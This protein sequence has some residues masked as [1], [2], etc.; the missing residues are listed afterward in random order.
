VKVLMLM[1][2]WLRLWSGL[3]TRFW[4]DR[5]L[6]QQHN[7]IEQNQLSF[8]Q[9]LPFPSFL[10]TNIIAIN[11]C[12]LVFKIEEHALRGS[13][14][15]G[16]TGSRCQGTSPIG[17]HLTQKWAFSVT[18]YR[19]EI[20]KYLPLPSAPLRGIAI[21]SHIFLYRAMRGI[22]YFSVPLRDNEHASLG[23]SPGKEPGRHI[24]PMLSSRFLG[25]LYLADPCNH[26]FGTPH[27]A[28]GSCWSCFCGSPV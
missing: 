16:L 1:E 2:A 3:A 27:T 6:T 28:F 19:A 21:A 9:P 20:N 26:A 14:T 13:S 15:S 25:F 8:P 4:V 12:Y 23:A 10:S 11:Q 17:A 22:L 24:N 5:G 7:S 18:G